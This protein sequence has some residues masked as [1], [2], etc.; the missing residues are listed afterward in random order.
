MYSTVSFT[1]IKKSDETQKGNY[2][3]QFIVVTM[4]QTL[5]FNQS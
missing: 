4:T 3:E 5:F 1:L 2:F